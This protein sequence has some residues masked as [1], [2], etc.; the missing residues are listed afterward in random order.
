MV[1]PATCTLTMVAQTNTP[2][3][4]DYQFTNSYHFGTLT[5]GELSKGT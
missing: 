1:D 4:T 5:K 2:L 3:V